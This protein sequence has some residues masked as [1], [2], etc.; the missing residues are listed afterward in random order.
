MI[1]NLVLP[2][3][4]TKR[5]IL[6]LASQD[7]WE[8]IIDYYQL[9]QNHLQPFEPIR[10]KDFYTKSYWLKEINERLSKFREDRSLKFFV[11]LKNNPQEIIGAINFDNF[12][13][14]SFQACTLGY[15][16]AEKFE[17][18]GL[19][20]ESLQVAIK[21][22]FDELNLHRIMAVYI[23]HNQRSGKLLKRLGF[24]VEGYM[25]DYLMINGQWQDH[26]FT[27]LININWQLKTGKFH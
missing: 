1:N 16:I 5:I 23:P 19:M 9:N 21:Y 11:F 7:D 8:K 12:V 6:R 14:G 13:R 10:S 25:S 17:G 27:S 4:K 24:V 20:S 15:G 2:V 18:K 22:V 26:I 3:L